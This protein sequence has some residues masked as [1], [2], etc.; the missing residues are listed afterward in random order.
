MP[1][2]TDETE[3]GRTV[4]VTLDKVPVGRKALNEAMAQKV[5]AGQFSYEPPDRSGA[6]KVL[7]LATSAGKGA[8]GVLKDIAV[9]AVPAAVGAMRGAQMGAPLGPWGVAGGGLAGAVAGGITG[10]AG[11]EAVDLGERLATGQPPRPTG[12]VV[13]D[14]VLG[15]GR[16]GVEMTPPGAVAGGMERVLSGDPYGGILQAGLGAIGLPQTGPLLGVAGAAGARAVA[17]GRAKIAE[18]ADRV[19]IHLT[20]AQQSGSPFLESAEALMQ[21]TGGGAGAYRKFATAQNE[22]AM[23]AQQNLVQQATGSALTDAATRGNRFGMLLREQ[24]EKMKR[25]GRNKEAEFYREAD[26]ASPVVLAELETQ[27]RALRAEQPSLPSLRN[28]RLDSI[29]DDILGIKPKVELTRQEG[30][31]F[32]AP[33]IPQ[34]MSAGRTGA[35]AAELAGGQR[36]LDLGQVGQR[37]S[38]FQNEMPGLPGSGNPTLGAA[39][40]LVTGRAITP[41]GPVTAEASRVRTLA[42]VRRIRTALG[43]MAF[44][45]RGAIPDVPQAQAQQLWAATTRDLDAFAAGHINPQVVP[46]WQEAREYTSRLHST[47]DGTWYAHLLDDKRS[48]AD[49][50]RQLFNPRDQTMLRDAKVMTS[51]DGWKLIQQQW[52]DDVLSTTTRKVPAGEMVLGKQF[53]DRVA[54]DRAVIKEL[55]DPETAQAIGELGDVMRTAEST[56]SVTRNRAFTTAL[57]ELFQARG[58]FRALSETSPVVGV[59]KAS[60]MI[61]APWALSQ[62]MMHPTTARMIAGA[63]RNKTLGPETAQSVVDYF[64]RF[65]IGPG[66]RTGAAAIVNPRSPDPEE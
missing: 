36:P 6:Q 25:L 44:P 7:D 57:V 12:D 51:D 61:A 63:A 28:S 41:A 64:M 31:V 66:A 38:S 56:M 35:A 22:Q 11:R 33:D 40:N 27:A 59:A 17:A 32:G 29:I 43:E 13:R 20:A 34:S 53:A 19:G 4:Y 9:P 21:R 8:Y 60:T 14:V 23:A 49:A 52:F 26:A 16:F 65:G 1:V 37:R 54:R 5:A 62:A 2:F 24:F 48:L 15:G 55:F 45:S 10:Y 18:T 3:D 47:A 39:E 46:K 58:L 50:S 30:A 42:D